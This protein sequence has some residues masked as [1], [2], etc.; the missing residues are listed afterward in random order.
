MMDFSKLN[1][2]INWCPPYSNTYERIRELEA[3]LAKT[4]EGL[5]IAVE[6]MVKRW[7]PVNDR[8]PSDPRYPKIEPVLILCNNGERG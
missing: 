3:E 2:L 6:A 4:K 7:I 8:L 5:S 1:L